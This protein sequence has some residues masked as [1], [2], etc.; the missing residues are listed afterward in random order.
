[1]KDIVEVV[2]REVQTGIET[3]VPDEDT[4]ASSRDDKNP[5]TRS[6][7]DGFSVEHTPTQLTDDAVETLDNWVGDDYLQTADEGDIVAHLDM[8]L[9]LLIA[10]RGEVCGKELLQDLRRTFG[11]DLSPGTVY[12]HL[13]DL[14]DSG[15]L[16]SRELKQ[17]KLYS[18]ADE[19]DVLNDIK[20]KLNRQIVSRLVLKALLVD[21]K[22]SQRQ[23]RQ[24]DGVKSE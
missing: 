23:P 20:E 11:V 24:Q 22:E 6:D 13:S 16:T 2:G 14:Q 10:V 4:S 17:R 5:L 21:S 7:S 3:S 9:L 19:R 8:V 1:M 18:L 15:E 12:P